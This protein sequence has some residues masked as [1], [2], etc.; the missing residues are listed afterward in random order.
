MQLECAR[1]LHVTLLTPVLMYDSEIRIWKEERPRIRVIQMDNL[2]GLLGI[3]RMDKGIRE[4]LRVI[5]GADERINEGILW[6]FGLVERMENDRIAK[7]A[8]VGECAGNH[9]LGRLW[10]RWINTVKDYLKKSSLD[11]KQ[12]RHYGA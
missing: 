10:K 1:V 3:R 12:A 5:K 9:L 11:A 2:R 6:W 7:R 4:L 8:Y